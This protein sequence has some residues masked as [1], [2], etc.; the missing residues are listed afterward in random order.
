MRG[1]PSTDVIT[2]ASIENET[3]VDVFGITEA[4][5]WLL[6]RFGDVIGWVFRDLIIINGDLAV[7]P[8][9]RADG[10]PLIPPTATPPTTPGP[11]TATAT[12]TEL[13]TPVISQPA[14]Q[15]V[16]GN[17]PPPAPEA[18]EMVLIVGGEKIPANP[19]E[20][21][22]VIAN[23]RSLALR[24]ENATVQLWGGLIGEVGAGWV[25]APAELLWAGAQL[26]VKAQPDPSDP[27][28]L[29]AER[30]RIVAP[31]T[32][33]RASVLSYPALAASVSLNSALALIGSREQSGVYL[34]EDAGTARPLLANEQE[35]NW[36]SGD[37][38][39]GILISAPDLPTGANTFSWVRTDGTGLQIFAQP[40]FRIRG[41]AGDAYGGLWWIETP[42]ASLDRWQLWQYD[43][44]AG[45][46]VL[47]LQASGELFSTGSRIV[48][49]SLAPVLLAARPNLAADPGAGSTVTLLLDTLD[50]STQEL[51][52]GVF[53]LVV[54]SAGDGPGQVV[55]APQ[56][57][58]APEDYRGPLQISPD[59]GRL[60]YF[61]FNPE[62]PSLTSGQIRPPNTV[63]LLTLEGRGANTIRTVYATETQF[64]FLAPNLA[65][66]GNDRLYLAR[67]RFAEG[68]IFGVD[69]FSIVAV[70]LP[71]PGSQ[72]AG[73]IL[74][75][76][77]E[78][79]NQQKLRDFAACRTGESALMVIEG[80]DGS[81]Q[82]ARWDHAGRPEP[83]FGLTSILTRTF[84]CW[85]VP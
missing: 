10:T 65:W 72:S 40:F 9:Y 8:L 26:Q 28:L 49:P 56:L 80:A 16:A 27:T 25:A 78:L 43:P 54:Q 20:P 2:I 17:G 37:D 71:A 19:L 38:A 52:K 33:E 46:I 29:I 18:D 61:Y 6:I 35:A 77:Y 11:P 70:Q 73:Q 42:Q 68:Q 57:L 85:R 22:P 63:R 34:L 4:G 69:R 14:A 39:A 59:R 84:I 47:R 44:I 1:G 21:I 30:V 75:S 51:Y 60:A 50:N 55:G 31:P 58:L 13:S 64:E 24:V 62:H 3:P 48:N 83:L 41:V 76:N 67:S 15:P 36:V 32:L 23:D 81:L 79:P 82:L 45:N 7:L 66:Q 74:A 12:P 53:Q 5:D